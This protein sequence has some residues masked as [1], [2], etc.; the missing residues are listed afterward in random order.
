MSSGTFIKV[1]RY[2][3][4]YHY[5]DKELLKEDISTAKIKLEQAKAS[6]LALSMAT[7]KDLTPDGEDPCDYIEICFNRKFEEYIEADYN[8]FALQDILDG[9]ETKEEF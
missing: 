6:L 3:K 9:W 8:L 1:K 2:Y 5:K 4:H 7:P